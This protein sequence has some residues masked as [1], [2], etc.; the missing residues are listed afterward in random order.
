MMSRLRRAVITRQVVLAATAAAVAAGAGACGSSP[1]ADDVAAGSSSKAAIPVG[2]IYDLSGPLGIVGKPKVDATK[3]AIK[4]IN[5]N[6]GVLG[7][8]LKLIS[9]D[10]QSDNAKYTQYATAL[11]GQD[12][13]VAVAA[14]ITSASREA[15]RPIIDRT[16]TVYF[17]DQL[18]EGGVCDKNV[19]STG[20]VPAQQL[21]QLISYAVQKFGKRVYIAAADYNFGHFEAT[22]AKKYVSE[23]GGQV[24]RTDFI[25]LDNTD[26]G[27]VLNTLQATKPD[28]MISLLVGGNHMSFY[29]QFA[30][31]GLAKSIKIVTPLFG[32]GQE[33]IVVGPKASA[34]ITVAFPYLQE[35]DTPANKDFVAKWHAAYGSGYP[36]ITNSAVAVWNDWHLWAKAVEKARSTDRD[37]VIAALESGISIESPSGTVTMNGGSHHVTQNV[38]LAEAT[39]SGAF[40]ILQTEPAVPPVYENEV[41]DLVKNPTLNKQFIP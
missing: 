34:G 6:G 36:Y 30:A 37:K 25:P 28:V 39:D 14:G 16:K 35:L 4:D 27:S 32:D 10:A 23:A 1:N 2:S 5:D 29:R 41:C 7:R 11:T 24:L 40:K 15:I 22:W 18:Y 17:Y 13:V 21:H 8:K 12:H 38:S 3:L 31:A 26:F 19:F 9:Y 20:P 33:H